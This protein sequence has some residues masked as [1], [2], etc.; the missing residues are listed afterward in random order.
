MLGS[1]FSGKFVSTSLMQMSSSER[2][3]V[4]EEQITDLNLLTRPTNTRDP[5]S[6]G[7]EGESVE[8]DAIAPTELRRLVREAIQSDL[9]KDSIDNAH[10]EAR[11]RYVL[12]SMAEE[13]AR[14][15]EDGYSVELING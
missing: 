4:T 8:V 10:L 2:L 3:A 12:K 13:T 6:A 5:R 14:H 1:R 7:F 15:Q 9:S 11:I